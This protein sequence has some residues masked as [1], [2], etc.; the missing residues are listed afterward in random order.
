MAQN[1][2]S[3]TTLRNHR[4]KRQLE[5]IALHIDHLCAQYDTH[6]SAS[7]SEPVERESWG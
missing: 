1:N 7:T 2:T 5:A 3:S 6:M 4:H